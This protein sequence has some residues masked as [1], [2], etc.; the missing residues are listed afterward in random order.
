MRAMDLQAPSLESVLACLNE[1]LPFVTP[2]VPFVTLQNLASSSGAPIIPRIRLRNEIWRDAVS[3]LIDVC[4]GIVVLIDK[5]QSPGLLSELRYIHETGAV[6]KT[7]ALTRHESP[8]QVDTPDLLRAFVSESAE[9]NDSQHEEMGQLLEPIPAIPSS[10]DYAA[11][12]A[13]VR[14]AFGERWG[15]LQ[16]LRSL[17]WRDRVRARMAPTNSRPVA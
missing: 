5:R 8:D 13:A 15:F 9:D 11:A 16:D 1:D 14:A 6:G 12:A 2:D 7:V 4:D 17:P 3:S 10:G